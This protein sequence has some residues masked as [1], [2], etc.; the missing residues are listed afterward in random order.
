MLSVPAEIKLNWMNGQRYLVLV[1]YP[2][3]ESDLL[4]HVRYLC[5]RYHEP[6][7]GNSPI[8]ADLHTVISDKRGTL[9]SQT[10]YA[11]RTFV[12]PWDFIYLTSRPTI[13]LKKKSA[14][15]NNPRRSRKGVWLTWNVRK[16]LT[17]SFRL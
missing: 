1:H 17:N 2:W 11:S 10:I 15:Q 12:A 9:I 6:W 3:F 14:K 13:S 4:L 7:P 8:H 16:H 5:Y